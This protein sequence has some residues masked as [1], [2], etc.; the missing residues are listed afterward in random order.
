MHNRVAV[1]ERHVRVD[2]R[3]DGFRALHGRCGKVGRNAE[4]YISFVVGTRAV[5]QDHVDR[6]CAVAEQRRYLAEEP[7]GCRPVAFG[8]PF[9]HIVRNEACVDNERILV[10]RLAIGG[11]TVGYRKARI[12][13]YPAKLV[14]APCHGGYKCFR[15][16][17]AAL[18]IYVVAALN[19][20]YGFV[21][22]HEIG[23]H[24]FF[25]GG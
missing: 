11:F 14:A 24:H 9:A 3:Y 19:Q 4:A 21:S 8:N 12:Q 13:H 15:N 2:L 7:G 25:N 6:P 17:C 10:F 20:F 16:G 5:Q 1:A 23:Y 18:D 22:R